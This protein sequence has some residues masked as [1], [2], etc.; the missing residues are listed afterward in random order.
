MRERYDLGIPNSL[1]S[2]IGTPTC[3]GKYGGAAITDVEL[4]DINFAALWPIPLI[5]QKPDS[6]P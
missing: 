6:R 5:S 4:H 1:P 2:L 3:I